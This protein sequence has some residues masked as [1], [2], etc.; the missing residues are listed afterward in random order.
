MK[1]S[2]L[3]LPVS[4][5]MSS[6]C[7]GCDSAT[8]DHTSADDESSLPAS[9]SSIEPIYEENAFSNKVYALVNKSGD[10]KEFKD[11]YRNDV[12]FNELVDRQIGLIATEIIERLN[13]VYGV[14]NYQYSY[15]A[16]VDD[17]STWNQGEARGEE[18]KVHQSGDTYYVFLR[19]DNGDLIP[20]DA[21]SGGF[22]IEEYGTSFKAA[23]FRSDYDNNLNDYLGNPSAQA[24]SS[25]L[26][27]GN[28]PSDTFGPD[29]DTGY[30]INEQKLSVLSGSI[31]GENV[32]YLNGSVI[33][34]SDEPSYAWNWSEYFK[35]GTAID[36]LKY[37]IA[38]IIVNSG[39]EDDLSMVDF[40]VYGSDYDQLLGDISFLSNYLEDYYQA[41][42]RYVLDV[43]IGSQQVS[44]DNNSILSL[45]SIIERAKDYKT[46]AEYVMEDDFYNGRLQF[47]GDYYNETENGNN[48][49][50]NDL[51]SEATLLTNYAYINNNTGTRTF[52]E[53]YEYLVN[54]ADDFVCLKVLADAYI[55]GYENFID[56]YVL[57]YG[58]DGS[59]YIDE[60]QTVKSFNQIEFPY[61]FADM[62]NCRNIKN[63]ETTV[64]SILGA[65][66]S[67]TFTENTHAGTYD[68][69]LL[70][71]SV[72][73]SYVRVGLDR[74]IGTLRD[75]GTISDGNARFGEARNYSTFII[76]ASD[77]VNDLSHYDLDLYIGDND[78]DLAL[79]ITVQTVNHD[80]NDNKAQLG[81]DDSAER[82]DMVNDK[83]L[84]KRNED[85]HATFNLPKL[86]RIDPD[87][88]EYR[89]IEGNIYQS[90][91]SDAVKDSLIITIKAY[92]A[93]G[94]EIDL[95]TEFGVCISLNNTYQIN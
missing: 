27:N 2:L 30:E 20:A 53:E 75:L 21:T 77:S 69:S 1:R 15:D 64:A 13:D 72:Y 36:R 51:F 82:L 32:Y 71:R 8:L 16:D 66:S 93:N 26:L 41:I 95:S 78:R 14:D 67:Q 48:Y 43:V 58:I 52:E 84:I 7:A 79:E 40:I 87:V 49:R 10:A 19:D 35:D 88:Q 23:Y 33:S 76:P 11:Y 42:S 5:L 92:D 56:F 31:Y 34:L 54:G 61:K 46:T 47:V 29:N 22:F 60:A 81:N 74:D 25:F 83:F 89:Y 86:T 90:N 4:L 38:D 68:P 44:N 59:G 62:V 80:M 73:A 28:V 3:V 45:S 24:L 57:Y 65:V 70:G 39:Y 6:L 63:Y 50:L 9:T 91:P 18:Y 37:A 12:S 17:F 85:W 94:E 55:S